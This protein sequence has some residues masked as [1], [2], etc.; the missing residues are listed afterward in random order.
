M[1]FAFVLA[2][3]SVLDTHYYWLLALSLAFGF[4]MAWSIGANDVANA[5][6]TSVGSGALTLKKAL[7][8]AGVLEFLGAVLVGQHVT[9]VIGGGIVPPQAFED[10]PE[11][12][13]FGMLA[14]LLASGTWL[15]TATYFGLPVS[16]THSI[17][18]AIIGFGIVILPNF[19]FSDDPQQRVE[20]SKVGQIVASWVVSP[21]LAG[22]LSF[23]IFTI[24]QRRVLFQRDLV[25]A[26]RSTAPY[27]VFAVVFTLTLVTLWKGLKPLKLDFDLWEACAL[28][29]ILS[30]IGAVAAIPVFARIAAAA[31][32][33]DQEPEGSAANPIVAEELERLETRTRRLMVIATGEIREGLRRIRNDFATL[34]GQIV[35]PERRG[36]DWGTSELRSVE[37]MFTYLQ[38]MSACAVAF[39]HGANDVANAIGPV[40]GILRV[41]HDSVQAVGAMEE[42]NHRLTT[43]GILIIGAIGIVM[44]LAMW[45]RRVIETIGRRITELTPTRG[46]AAEFGAAVTIL[47]A[48][49]FALPVSTTHTLVGAVFGVGLARGVGALDL[50]VVRDIAASWIITLPAGAILAMLYYSILAAI[51]T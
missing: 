34:R 10:M 19:G 18:G 41:L 35:L 46:F 2:Q 44:G 43:F 45:G 24:I 13:V 40:Q 39:A 50:R 51:F 12:Y 23:I 8:V 47:L 14:A 27:F 5:M 36:P 37:Q 48:S 4:I 26:S 49:R 7:I 11:K 42:P 29:S 30:L 20:W 9:G 32:G 17:V 16:T 25:H 28:A 15:I 31:N 1:N 33:K 22:A 3:A 21:A 38:V 6:G